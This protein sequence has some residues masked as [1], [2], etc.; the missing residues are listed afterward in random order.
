MENKSFTATIE[1]ARSPQEVFKSITADV[2]KW[3]GGKDWSSLFK[4]KIS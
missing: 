3:W 4:A 2:G 1:V